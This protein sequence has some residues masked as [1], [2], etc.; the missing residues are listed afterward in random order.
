MAKLNDAFV[1]E[2]LQTYEPILYYDSDNK[3][4]FIFENC[5]TLS[6]ECTDC[7]SGEQGCTLGS[8][9]FSSL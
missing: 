1:Q 2:L 4:C 7:T 5:P 8:S 6:E 9:T 3:V